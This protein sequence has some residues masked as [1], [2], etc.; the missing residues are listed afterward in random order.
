[1]KNIEELSLMPLNNDAKFERK[2][3]CAFKDDM[4]N[5]ANFHQS[6]FG[7]LKIGTLIGSFY[8]K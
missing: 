8:P 7:S 2:I 3:T 5:L 4:R 6:M 1:M